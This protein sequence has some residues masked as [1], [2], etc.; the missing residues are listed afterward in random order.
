MTPQTLSEKE[1]NSRSSQAIERT[2]AAGGLMSINCYGNFYYFVEASGAISVRSN[3]S[4]WIPHN[5]GTGEQYPEDNF[6]ERLE[7]RNDGDE[8]VSITLFVGFDTYI[9]NRFTVIPGRLDSILFTQDAPTAIIP[10]ELDLDPETTQNFDG[11]PPTG[12]L[13]RKEIW[14]IKNGPD[15]DPWFVDADDNKIIPILEASDGPAFVLNV[16]G[17]ISVRNFDDTNNA[18]VTVSENWF[19]S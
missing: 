10:T 2:I 16:S 18:A 11:T 19:V 1:K 14:A 7:I 15:G 13:Q 12:Y 4:A 5:A 3:K 8:E 17:A 6:F 9:D